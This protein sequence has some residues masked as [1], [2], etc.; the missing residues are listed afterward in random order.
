MCLWEVGDKSMDIS[1]RRTR[2]ENRTE[3][4]MENEMETLRAFLK[5]QSAF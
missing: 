5:A 1:I 3:N 4:E 2:P